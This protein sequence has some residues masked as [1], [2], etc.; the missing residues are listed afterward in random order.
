[1]PRADGHLQHLG[2]DFARPDE[3]FDGVLQ[4]FNPLPARAANIHDGGGRRQFQLHRQIHFVADENP[5][6]SGKLGKI[7]FIRRRQLF[8]GVEHVQNQFRLRE[9]GAAAADALAFNLVARLAQAG[10]VNEHDRQAADVRGLLNRVARRAGNGRND[11]AVMAKQLVEQTGFAGVRP[12]DNR[13]ADAA[14]Q[15]LPLVRRA[16]QLVHEGDARFEPLR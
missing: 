7:I 15:N 5:F 4:R 12:A 13:R 14:P 10:G 2:L 1:M 9:R 8:A 6:F 11:G 16:E 3:R